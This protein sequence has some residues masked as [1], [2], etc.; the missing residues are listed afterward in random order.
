MKKAYSIREYKD[1]DEKGILELTE[2]VFGKVADETQWLEWWQ[3]EFMDNPAGRARIWLAVHKDKIVGMYPLIW[4]NMKIANEI[5]KGSQNIDLMTHPNY[6]HQGIFYTLEKKALAEMEKERTY[7]TYGF[8]NDAAY[9][10]HLK[11]AWFDVGTSRPLIKPLNLENILKRY[12][13]NKFLTKAGTLAGNLLINLLYRTIKP[14]QVN[15]ITITMVSSFDERINDFWN[16]VSND[17]NIIVIR[18]KAYLNWRYID[19]PDKEYTIYLAEKDGE[20]CGYVILRCVN[21]RNLIQ[22]YICD[23]IAPLEQGEVVHCLISKAVEFFKEQSA[24]LAIF[25]RLANNRLGGYFNK[26]GFMPLYFKKSCF[27]ARSNSDRIPIAYLRKP[28][29]WFIHIGDSDLI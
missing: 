5:V 28:E 6:Q 8:P 1:G 17:Y 23:I 9:P 24:D 2:A 4:M 18:N 13:A 14:P 20:I 10:G 11:N 7:V 29:H 22:G 21:Q 3:W 27:M 15:N 26:H 25:T 19:I 16:R 12:V